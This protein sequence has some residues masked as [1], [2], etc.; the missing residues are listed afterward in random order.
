M[1][2]IH[3]KSHDANP[4]FKINATLVDTGSIVLLAY[5]FELKNEIV[6]YND[7][8]LSKDT[9]SGKRVCAKIPKDIFYKE[10]DRFKAKL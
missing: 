5:N 10:I 2:E 9:H 7:L 1:K 4:H 3:Y 6:G 8:F